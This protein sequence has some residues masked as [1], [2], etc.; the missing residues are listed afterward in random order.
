MKAHPGQV[1]H[2]QTIGLS[3]SNSTGVMGNVVDGYLQRVVVA[4][5]DHRDRVT[6]ENHVDTGV[7]CRSCAGRVVRGQH[8]QRIFSRPNFAGRNLWNGDL[9]HRYLLTVQCAEATGSVIEST[10]TTT[11][12]RKIIPRR[13]RRPMALF[14]VN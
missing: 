14:V 2:D 12:A 8:D 9:R 11:G 3:A 4:E 7:A 13:R 1:A 10:G 6:D 5:H